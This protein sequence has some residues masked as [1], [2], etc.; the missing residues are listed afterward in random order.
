MPSAP[1]GLAGAGAPAG[2]LR[3]AGTEHA[4]TRVNGGFSGVPVTGA[5]DAV[6]PG[7]APPIPGPSAMRDPLW[8]APGPPRRH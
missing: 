5:A 2:E 8:R 4:V 3:Q 1:G 7:I 6:A